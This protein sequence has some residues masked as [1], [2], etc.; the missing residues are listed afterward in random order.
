MNRSIFSTV[1][2]AV[3]AIAANA[4]AMPAFD[5]SGTASSVYQWS[6]ATK[7][8]DIDRKDGRAFLWIPEKCERLA[9][10]VIGQ[11]NMIE[12]PIFETPAF[13]D[14]LAKAN[15]GIV[16]ISPIQ[17]GMWKAGLREKLWLEDILT[18]F[19]GESGYDEL[20]TCP[21]AIIGHSAMAMWPYMQCAA[22]KERA[23]AGV[24]IKGAWADRKTEW[25]SDKVGR[26][27]AGIP[28]LLLDGEYE[29]AE[30]RAQKSRDF[31]NAFPDVPF[32]FCGE[33]G[34]G[35]FDVS[36]ELSHYLGVYFR[37][38]IAFREQGA[39]SEGWLMERWKRH[40]APSCEPAPVA[41]YKGERKEAYWYFDE[42]MVKE[43]QFLQERFRAQKKT[44]LVGYRF[45]GAELPQHQDHLQ[46]HIPFKGE[47]TFTFE[48]IFTENVE[49]FR[50]ADW[51]GLKAGA[52][53]PH[54]A[55]EGVLYVQKICGPCT[56]IGE[57]KYELCFQRG[58][59]M[60]EPDKTIDICFQAVFPGDGEYQ[61]AV[62]QSRMRVRAPKKP[63]D[64]KGY[65]IRE[66]S[67]TIDA[68]TGKIMMQPL[69]PRAKKPH[70]VTVVEWTWGGEE[71]A[72]EIV[73]EGIETRLLNSPFRDNA[74]RERAF[75]E[76]VNPRALTRMFRVTAGLQGLEEDDGVIQFLRGWEAADIELRGH[77]CGHWLSGMAS[78]YELTRDETVKARAA[79]VVHI[80]A[81]CQ[82]ANG[83][84]YLSAFP[85]SD[86]D[87][88]IAG[89]RVWAPW[90]VLHKILAGLI[91]QWQICG[92]IEAL[93]VAKKFGDWTAAK[94][95][96]LTE[97]QRKTM[98]RREFGGIGESLILLA[99]I[100]KDERYRKAAEVF[101]QDDLYKQI[102][103]KHANTLIPKVIAD[104]RYSRGVG[105]GMQDEAQKFWADVI[106]HYMYAPGCVSTKEAFRGPDRQGD[107]L[108]GVTGE[109]CCTY[110]LLKLARLL[111]TPERA[112][113]ADY[114]ERAVWNHILGQ[115]EPID[116]HLTYFMPVMTGS[117]KL[118][119]RSNDSFWCCCGSAM[120]SHTKYQRLIAEERDGALY[121]NNF[122]PAEI[123]WKG[124][125]LRLETK[126]PAE[127]K[128]R[129]VVVSG[130]GSVGSGEHM[131][132]F[133]RRP[134]W[135]LAAKNAENA[136]SCYEEYVRDW[137]SGD[138]IDIDLL[139]DW[140]TES[141][142][143][144]D[145]TKHTAVFYGPILMAAR[146]GVEGMR[147]D[148]TR[149]C[150]Y[151]AHDFAVPEHLKSVKLESPETWERLAP[152]PPYDRGMDG[153]SPEVPEPFVEPTFKTP[154]GLVVS[155]YWAIHGE[156]LCVYFDE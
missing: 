24:S 138:V 41:E 147:K 121:I 122:I 59:P 129:I 114:E 37:K 76:S 11:R 113:I 144:K 40:E 86:I 101:R 54:P 12:E 104:V 142:I 71:K 63:T 140:R 115:M 99:N 26:A 102:N 109:T 119:S 45:E 68:K 137:K 29:D 103:G 64:F 55:D 73:T 6:V 8:L 42:E 77:T 83:N 118:Q 80:L 34:A 107:F 131:K 56:K 132:I 2:V 141:V 9:G 18:R 85:E 135:V 90:Y 53:A 81:E 23:F 13:R 98:L 154:S 128:A 31:C 124:L 21:V 35:H 72:N 89:T 149:S 67:A 62:Q 30:N 69:P 10:V 87:K 46:I 22:M 94:V 127:E 95:L 125:T 36:D 15:L 65:Y 20:S 112:D 52:T 48:P 92:N 126:F 14:E 70:R 110:N 51:V 91:D 78:L 100:T 3:T 39:G 123:R 17:G 61:R 153:A 93:D 79:E 136:K 38:A 7:P 50:L 16:F 58:C 47:T 145:G 57:N 106:S 134:F 66:G 49:E 130:Q 150:N 82:A 97:E 96:P 32:S 4:A 74:M 1:F 105:C 139:C 152:P 120:E 43:T 84:G 133:V 143:S 117:Y 116:G 44:P 108:T 5:Y 33:D 146:L 75:M 25:A 88:I 148:A 28:F 60:P 111:W 155:P 27:L 151:Y 19:A 156:R